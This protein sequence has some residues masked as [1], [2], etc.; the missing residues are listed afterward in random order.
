MEY[1]HILQY[2]NFSNEWPQF[3]KSIGLGQSLQLPWENKGTGNE[4]SNYFEGLKAGYKK[5][6]YEKFRED[7]DMFGYS[8][9]EKF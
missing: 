5:K 9:T 6:L 2:E 1:T 7:F 8:M 4:L 3:L